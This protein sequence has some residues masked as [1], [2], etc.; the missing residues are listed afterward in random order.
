M[1]EVVNN[2]GVLDEPL[3]SENL[4]SHRDVFARLGV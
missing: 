3:D 1:G 2:E 4:Q